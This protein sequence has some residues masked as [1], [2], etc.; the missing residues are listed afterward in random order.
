LG[1]VLLK[2][3]IVNNIFEHPNGVDADTSAEMMRSFCTFHFSSYI[4]LSLYK[5][6]DFGLMNFKFHPYAFGV[7]TQSPISTSPLRKLPLITTFIFLL[8]Q[9]TINHA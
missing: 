1:D 7:G 5:R 3:T 8:I 2:R 4:Y 6:R 9:K